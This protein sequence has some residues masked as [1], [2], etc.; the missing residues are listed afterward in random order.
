MDIRRRI[1]SYWKLSG[2]RL[3]RH[4]TLPGDEKRV[5][6]TYLNYAPKGSNRPERWHFIGS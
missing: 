6:G 5:L 4:L 1:E 3:L 2:F